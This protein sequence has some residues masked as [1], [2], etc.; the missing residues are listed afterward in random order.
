MLTMPIDLPRPISRFQS[1]L[2]HCLA[3]FGHWLALSIQLPFSCSSLR[4]LP[5]LIGPNSTITST[6]ARFI[7]SIGDFAAPPIPI[8]YFSSANSNSFQS[9]GS[10]FFINSTTLIGCISF[11]STVDRFSIRFQSTV[12][13]NGRGEGHL[14]FFFMFF[15]RPRD[16]L[17]ADLIVITVDWTLVW[18]Y[19]LV[20]SVAVKAAA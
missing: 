17:L 1:Y 19:A 20:I 7:L 16:W 4:L 15:Y 8:R 6:S 12:N 3:Y 18:R 11:I 5:Q 2:F 9:S 10:S 14:F 13:E